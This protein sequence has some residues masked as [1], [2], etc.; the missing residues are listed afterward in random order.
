[1]PGRPSTAFR[2]LGKPIPSV[3][4]RSRQAV[5]GRRSPDRAL[6]K[7]PPVTG[8]RWRLWNGRV[9]P[10]LAARVAVDRRRQLGLSFRSTISTWIS[11]LSVSVAY[12]SSASSC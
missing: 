1:M 5:D 2:H 8:V 6:R 3:A 7:N 12:R 10:A 4:L 11:H 9:V